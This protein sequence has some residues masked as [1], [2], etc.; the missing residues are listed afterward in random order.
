MCTEGWCVRLWQKGLRE[1]GGNCLKYLIK[2]WN[3]KEG[4]GNKDLKKKG[5]GGCKPPYKL[6]I[7]KSRKGVPQ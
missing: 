1:S 6:C 4:R 7:K 3:R 5:A 2:W